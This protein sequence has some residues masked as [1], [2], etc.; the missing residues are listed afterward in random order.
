MNK[1]L[2]LSALLCLSILLP[3]QVSFKAKPKKQPGTTPLSFSARSIQ[4]KTS[5]KSASFSRYPTL[6]QL[7]KAPLNSNGNIQTKIMQ[8]SLPV[9]IEKQT[10]N[11]KSTGAF[12]PEDKVARFFQS[13]DH[14]TR[15]DAATTS[16]RIDKNET[17]RLGIQHIKA[18][19]YFKGIEVYGAQSVLHLSTE[20]ERFTGRIRHIQP[21]FDTAPGIS[22]GEAIRVVQ[23]DIQNHTLLRQ[24]SEQEQKLLRY[25]EPS[26]KPLI[27]KNQDQSD[28]LAWEV[29]IR[30]NFIERWI[31]FVDA[32]T[33]TIL[34]FFNA[35][36]SDGPV[37]AQAY[38]R[39]NRLRT[40]NTYLDNGT[41][42]LADFSQPMYNQAKNEGI[43]VTYDANHTSSN[44]LN[45]SIIQSANNEWNN[46]TAVSAHA[47][48]A[49][50]FQ[51]FYTTFGRN[52]I[53]GDGGN[54]L[55]FINVTDDNG[56]SMANAYWNGEAAFYGNGG[57][58][59][60]PLAGAQDVISH[61]LGHGVVQNTAN[62]EYRGQSGAINETY[63]DIF[64]SMVD[65]EDWLVGEDIV[66]PSQF[67]AGSMRN[68][69]DPHNG[70]AFQDWD[71]GWQPKHLSEIYLGE[72]DNGGVH[73]NNSIG[74]HAF[75]LYASKISK[76]KA[77]Q[78]FYRA[79]DHYLT[80]Y[81]Q[82]IDFR[83][84]VV[85]AARDLYGNN[86]TEMTEAGKAF[87][88]VGVYGE[89]PV[90]KEQEYEANT[91]EDFLMSY[92]T[93]ENT[94]TTLYRSSVNGEDFLPITATDMKGK[95]SIT[96]DGSAL[97]FAGTDDYMKFILLD[98]DQ[99]EENDLSSDAFW[100]NV[101]VSKDGN[102]VAGIST[103]V[104]TAIYVFDLVSGNAI[105]F[106]LYNPTT[107]HDNMNAGG[108][109]YADV[110][111]FD[112]TGEYLIYDA[113]NVLTSTTYED[114]YYWDIGFIHVWD[115]Q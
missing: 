50:T 60:K 2:F 61:E 42:I 97:V 43:I 115:N 41:Y 90:E 18:T 29:E 31:Y 87:D 66:I 105:K 59:F 27:Y 3:A 103:E 17:D 22:R 11:L 24:L 92:D 69:A 7:T 88:A 21:D 23:S 39:N 64:G 114:I 62:L 6:P 111:E 30:P 110:I 80:K 51:Y 20:N 77:E 19:Q 113:H 99:I 70:L 35:T 82:F 25:K 37:T 55:S 57:S 26:I 13:V 53:N 86:S 33:G 52:S 63:A 71:A 68:M 107:S 1:M 94:N 4:G 15:L 47:N 65:R 102:R 58:L 49:T 98:G 83:I 109:L 93:D 76:E 95:V 8:G 36:C 16:F 54:I 12:L 73:I 96:D 91:G 46:A 38:D 5:L 32:K 10:G 34:D 67:P 112:H 81:A 74:N 78:V 44:N 45:F 14:L 79:L 104:D 84:A 40:L 56:E 106:M 101:A 89:E 75:Y 9:Y 85:Q 48:T 28:H 72:G 100:D 108:V